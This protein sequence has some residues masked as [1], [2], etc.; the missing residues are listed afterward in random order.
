LHLEALA[1]RAAGRGDLAEAFKV[2]DGDGGAEGENGDEDA[3]ADR[4][5]GHDAG[6]AI[7]AAPDDE[8]G[9]DGDKE[10]KESADEE[11]VVEGEGDGGA[12]T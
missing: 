10:F 5:A 2:E 3:E 9:R 4:G 11:P 6:A 1:G 12:S 7:A 8:V